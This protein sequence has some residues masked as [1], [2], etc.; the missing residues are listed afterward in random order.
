[1]GV[2]VARRGA[3]RKVSTRAASKTAAKILELLQHSDAELSVALVGDKEIRE[4]NAEFRGKNEPTDVLAFPAAGRPPAEMAVLGDVVISVERA[5]RQAR[6]RKKTFEDEI[7]TLLIHGVLHLL[8]YDH[9]RSRRDAKIM[10]GME[11]KIHRILCDEGFF[12]V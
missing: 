8:G 6:E 9:E 10:A 3:G 2:D 11:K 4:L 1:M 12:K 5:R 7:V